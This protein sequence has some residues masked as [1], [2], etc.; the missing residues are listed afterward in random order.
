MGLYF[1]WALKL[2]FGRILRAN[3]E[4]E[5][6]PR[7]HILGAEPVKAEVLAEK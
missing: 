2:N 3:K 4:I 7:P 5:E 1:V 6:A